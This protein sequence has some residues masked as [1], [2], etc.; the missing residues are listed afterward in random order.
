M[1]DKRGVKPFIITNYMGLFIEIYQVCRTHPSL[2]NILK[3]EDCVWLV[4]RVVIFILFSMSFPCLFCL[5]LQGMV[6][7]L[8]QKIILSILIFTMSYK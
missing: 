6:T 3:Y 5:K 8:V 4:F 2:F 1:L 7:I